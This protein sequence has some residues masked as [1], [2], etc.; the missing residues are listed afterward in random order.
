[1]IKNFKEFLNE[2][3]DRDRTSSGTWRSYIHFDE[4]TK[5]II[6]DFI[7]EDEHC[8]HPKSYKIAE[9]IY[10]LLSDWYDENHSDDSYALDDEV[11][12]VSTKFLYH[13]SSGYYDSAPD[14]TYET[15]GEFEYDDTDVVEEYYNNIVEFFDT[16]TE[17]SKMK[18]YF[19]YE[20][21]DD[22]I[23]DIA[24]EEFDECEGEF[25]EY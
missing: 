14:Y 5:R 18:D 17:F 9:S 25:D 16:D 4:V 8:D 13:E 7:H 10:D 3:I 2:K 12:R 23:K 19:A 21:F 20:K 24:Q 22:T 11:V 15:V 1:M 6:A